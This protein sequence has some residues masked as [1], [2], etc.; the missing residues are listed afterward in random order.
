MAAGLF[1]VVHRPLH[2]DAV[3][4]TACPQLVHRSIQFHQVVTV[5]VMWIGRSS[6]KPPST[7]FLAPPGDHLFAI[8][9]QKV[10]AVMVSDANVR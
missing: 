4:T 1:Q 5:C 6:L 3:A 10:L 9:K 7:V 8:G 2:R